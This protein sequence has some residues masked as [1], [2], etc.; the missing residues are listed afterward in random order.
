MSSQTRSMRSSST[1]SN[2]R[3]PSTSP[4]PAPVILPRGEGDVN[5]PRGSAHR[6]N[7]AENL[8]V[9]PPVPVGS[10]PLPDPGDL[11]SILGDR[12]G[13]ERRDRGAEGSASNLFGSAQFSLLE[14]ERLIDQINLRTVRGASDTTRE[15]Q[16][17][18]PIVANVRANL[19]QRFN[20]LVGGFQPMGGSN[21]LLSGMS[22]FRATPPVGH[23]R[24][25]GVLT[26][27]RDF[28][29][30]LK[31]YHDKLKRSN[32]TIATSM[33]LTTLYEVFQVI[34]PLVVQD[35]VEL[36]SVQGQLDWLYKSF[37]DLVPLQM[38]KTFEYKAKT[39]LQ[40]VRS[41]SELTAVLG[42][43]LFKVDS[44]PMGM[45]TLFDNYKLNIH[46]E[47]LEQ[48]AAMQLDRAK[49]AFL[50]PSTFVEGCIA[51]LAAYPT[52]QNTI[53]LYWKVGEGARLLTS[54]GDGIHVFNEGLLE[55]VGVH[56][57][58]YLEKV[59][60]T[61][62]A[63]G[64]KK[65]MASI[66]GIVNENPIDIPNNTLPGSG[67]SCKNCDLQGHVWKV[68]P[69]PLREDFP[70]CTYARC[71]DKGKHVGHLETQCFRK[72]PELANKNS[73]KREGPRFESPPK[74]S[75]VMES[76]DTVE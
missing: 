62:P 46:S 40:A 28:N 17:S 48:G 8:P 10:V 55:E 3:F 68:C 44:N 38:W 60:R 11:R 52:V 26:P 64:T 63:V 14:A 12:E 72:H 47:Y 73:R 45:K 37:A 39:E 59:Q 41:L 22:P 19:S 35:A 24:E 9:A 4:L 53:N 66:I 31:N 49:Q 7:T 71:I 34:T 69:S 50:S 58:N 5:R 65:V 1:R 23:D 25:V 15:L 2:A 42:R 56:M 20:S 54:F 61:L 74:R 67:G 21:R 75:R 57:L 51:M 43:Y 70:K 18:T 29:K 36:D 30:A 6:A 16:S 32:L 27:R 13:G 33:P 76:E